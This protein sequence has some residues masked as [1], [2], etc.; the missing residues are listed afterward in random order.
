MGFGEFWKVPGPRHV[1]ERASRR[2]SH[3]RHLPRPW[4]AAAFGP[5]RLP[6][7]DSGVVGGSRV[8]PSPNFPVPTHKKT[9]TDH[10]CPTTDS[11]REEVRGSKRKPLA[12]RQPGGGLRPRPAAP[13]QPEAR[14]RRARASARPPRPG[15]T[16]TATLKSTMDTLVLRCQHTCTMVLPRCGAWRSSEVRDALRSSSDSW[17]PAASSGD[18]AGGRQEGELTSLPSKKRAGRPFPAC[19]RG[20][21]AM[22]T[23]PRQPPWAGSHIIA[24]RACAWPRGVPPDPPAWEPLMVFYPAPLTSSRAGP[25]KGISLLAHNCSVPGCL[26]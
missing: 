18:S 2:F 11:T 4:L 3:D 15:P 17:S 1:R 14:P 13:Q 5:H 6:A 19:C 10:L 12:C 8:R 24:A 23:E 26:A 25:E 16:S 20:P 7:P 22:Q 9:H 21:T